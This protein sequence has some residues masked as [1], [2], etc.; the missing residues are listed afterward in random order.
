MRCFFCWILHP[1]LAAVFFFVSADAIPSSAFGDTCCRYNTLA[2]LIESEEF[3][4][5]GFIRAITAEQDRIDLF[6][7]GKIVE[8]V[9]NLEVSATTSIHD[10]P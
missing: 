3:V 5:M 6:I 1:S 10:F 4:E 7:S 8:T 2:D 9:N